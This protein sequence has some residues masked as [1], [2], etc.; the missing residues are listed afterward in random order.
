[1]P[2]T[3]NARWLNSL[4]NASVIVTPAIW[5]ELTMK[6][7]NQ[8]LV[9]ACLAAAT[10]CTAEQAPLGTEAERAKVAATEQAVTLRE[11]Q[12]QVATC[13]RAARGLIALAVCSTDFAEC[14]AQALVDLATEEDTLV[15]CAADA[16]ECLS[17]ADSP[18]DIR[19]CRA[20]YATCA[21]DVVAGTIDTVIDRTETVIEEIFETAGETIRGILGTTG[22]AI[23]VLNECREDARECLASVGTPA[24]ADYCRASFEMCAE[25]AIDLAESLIEP[26]PGPTPSE[27]VEGFEDCRTESTECLTAATTATRINECR[28]IL[29]ACVTDAVDLA[30]DTIEEIEDIA[31]ELLPPG[32][33]TPG[34]VVDCNWE[35]TEC[36]LSFELPTLCAADAIECL[37]TVD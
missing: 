16:N 23:A 19:A 7:I 25:N 31:D 3:T 29:D 33:P 8:V 5:E 37:A 20:E 9:A 17:A 6:A 10:G 2:A 34:E 18:A 15:D 1:V 28:D 13:V 22:D 30:E 24:A 11:C 14:N 35:L 12:A 27:V 26:L 32:V 4:D 36:L 21:D